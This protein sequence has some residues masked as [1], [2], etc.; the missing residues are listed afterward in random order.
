MS[1]I[2]YQIQ[3]P[4]LP[5]L[6]IGYF[7]KIG[8]NFYQVK[9]RKLWRRKLPSISSATKFI[10]PTYSGIT[11]NLDLN[12]L[13]HYRYLSIDADVNA[14]FY[15]GETK[16]LLSDYADIPLDTKIAGLSNPIQI[17]K[18]SYSNSMYI[19]LKSL[20]GTVNVYLEGFEYLIEKTEEKPTKY[21]D[22]A[23]NGDARFVGE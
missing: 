7:V 12:R 2:P 4:E 21:L 20:T 13:V 6:E 15:W 22:I 14:V 23:P 19:Y 3:K 16:P 11:G 5:K 17:D 1:F 9:Q 8:D 10:D 18:W